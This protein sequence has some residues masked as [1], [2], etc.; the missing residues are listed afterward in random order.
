MALIR[1]N[2][3]RMEAQKLLQHHLAWNHQH[4]PQPEYGIQ[5]MSSTMW[6]VLI[7]LHLLKFIYLD[8]G[9]LALNRKFNQTPMLKRLILLVYSPYNK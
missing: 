3:D 5:Q 7:V 6:P 8:V 4:L 1:H 9:T 2:S